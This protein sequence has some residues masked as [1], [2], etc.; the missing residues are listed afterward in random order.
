MLFVCAVA[1]LTLAGFVLG[2][3]STLALPAAI[4]GLSSIGLALA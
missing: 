3:S 2:A 1:L 4:A